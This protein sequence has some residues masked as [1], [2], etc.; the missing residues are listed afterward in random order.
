MKTKKPSSKKTSASKKGALKPKKEAPKKSRGFRWPVYV[1]VVALLLAGAAIGGAVWFYHN[2]ALPNVS[3]GSVVV[4]NMTPDQIRQA[5][6]QQESALNLTFVDNGKSITVPL[7]EIGIVVNQEATVRQVLEARRS[8]NVL[9]A[10]QLWRQQTVPLVFS[11][12]AGAVIDFAKRHFPTAFVD[13]KEPQLVYNSTT[14]QFDVQPGANGTG[15]DLKTFERTVPELARRPRSVT[16]ALTTA[17]VEPIIQADSLVSVKQQADQRSKL[18]LKFLLNEQEVYKA[19]PADIA[20]WAHFVPNPT[21]GTLN[22]EYDKAK[23]QQFL[24]DQVGPSIT[25]PPVDRKVVVDSQTGA[26]TVLQQGKKG[27]EIADTEGLTNEVLAA[28]N[29]NKSLSKEVA[30]TDAP[31]KTVTMKGDGKWIEVDISK[32]RATL[33]IGDTVVQSFLISS[34]R[35]GTPTRLGTF[36]VWSK[37][38]VQT[39][40][41]TIAGD[42][43]YIPNIKWVSY[44]DGGE[45]FHGTYWHHNFGHPMSHGC[46]N[47]T[48]DAAKI[49]YDFAPVGT[50]V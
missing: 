45:A 4:S 3:V 20:S 11:N 25:S 17:P 41:G 42:Y 6:K 15:F 34:G 5:I 29:A 32:Q 49:L 48:E 39:M 13:A 23:I 35:A 27:R 19:E 10:V 37:A 1:L 36:R 38:P 22:M 14:K 43:F 47:M 44:F 9:D 2:R 21:T 16:L 40:T 30:I 7:K 24:K 46:I 8:G 31:F 28:L 33:Y 12:D 26:E 18:E 50:K